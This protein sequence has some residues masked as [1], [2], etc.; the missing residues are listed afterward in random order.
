MFSKS[1]FW[2]G[3]RLLLSCFLLV[4]SARF[5]VVLRGYV[6]SFMFVLVYTCDSLISVKGGLA[7][8]YQKINTHVMGSLLKINLVTTL[9]LLRVK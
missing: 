3:L 9:K 7:R 4:V 6:L 8:C 2:G 1:N 5:G